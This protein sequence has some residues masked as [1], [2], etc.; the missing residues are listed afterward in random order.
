MPAFSI[1]AKV[2]QIVTKEVQLLIEAKTQELAEE[3]AKEVLAT[4]PG[5]L[6]YDPFIHRVVTKKANYWVPRSI[7][8]V[9]IKEEPNEAA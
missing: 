4:Y 5:P 6:D 2:D 7:E 1:L 9:A 8:F 3:K